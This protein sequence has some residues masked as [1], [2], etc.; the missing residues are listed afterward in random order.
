M[1]IW[2]RIAVRYMY[3][4]AIESM[5]VTTWVPSPGV[6]L[7]TMWSGDDQALEKGWMIPSCIMCSSSTWLLRD[8]LVVIAGA[9]LSRWTCSVD[10]VCD[11]MQNCVF[12]VW[13]H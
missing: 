3:C 1:Y 12:M 10:V 6:F 8:N 5:V 9:S 2:N 4:D 11:V 13:T 7:G